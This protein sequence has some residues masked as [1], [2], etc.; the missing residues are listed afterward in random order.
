MKTNIAPQ[1]DKEIQELIDKLTTR[2]HKAEQVD[3]MYV[4][5]DTG[6][7]DNAT[8]LVFY[9][10]L[11]TYGSGGARGNDPVTVPWICVRIELEGDDQ[12][13]ARELTSFLVDSF[14]K[15]DY[16]PF[17]DE[18]AFNGYF[19]KDERGGWTKYSMYVNPDFP[20]GMWENHT[21]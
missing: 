21:L 15:L 20:K 1:I 5:F 13:V 10:K 3:E 4:E 2:F 12:Q 14:K 16:T 8:G 7:V 17:H 18:D 9:P 11:L 19:S 6:I